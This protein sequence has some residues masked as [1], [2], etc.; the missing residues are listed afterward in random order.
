MAIA[1][2]VFLIIV[3]LSIFIRFFT[4]DGRNTAV[5][6]NGQIVLQ[7]E[8]N[9]RRVIGW[10]AYFAKHLYCYPEALK[11]G[12]PPHYN[13]D[14]LPAEL[15]KRMEEYLAPSYGVA[16]THE[17]HVVFQMVYDLFSRA[18]ILEKNKDYASALNCYLLILFSV[19]PLGDSYY[20]RPAILLERFKQYEAAIIICKMRYRYLHLDAGSR[21]GSKEQ[22]LADWKKREM[23][24]N[25]K[26]HK[27]V[28]V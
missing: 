14:S 20:H 2:L 11:Q 21:P 18:R 3:A 6:Y 5:R 24:L 13:W 10:D 22:L 15:N 19:V 1:L 23:R 17:E 7:K 28:T 27:K 4:P 9:G 25:G 26:L 12:I 16:D 8:I